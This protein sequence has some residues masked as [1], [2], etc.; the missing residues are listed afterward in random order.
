MYAIRSYYVDWERVATSGQQFAY[1]RIGDGL[2]VDS[3]FDRN[4]TEA[5]RVGVRRGAYQYF[6]PGTDALTQATQRTN[7]V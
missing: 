6:R 5:R 4:W 2:G 7:F 3:Q 1:I